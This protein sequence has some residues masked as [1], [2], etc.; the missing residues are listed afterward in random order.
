MRTDGRAHEM[1][2]WREKRLCE[3]DCSELR[4]SGLHCSEAERI[5]LYSSDLSGSEP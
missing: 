4:G 3:L 2:T 5:E 1:Q